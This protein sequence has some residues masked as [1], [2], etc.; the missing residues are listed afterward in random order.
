VCYYRHPKDVVADMVED[1]SMTDQL[2]GRFEQDSVTDQYGDNH[3]IFASVSSALW[4][5]HWNLK[6][7]SG[8]RVMVAVRVSGD[9]FIVTGKR[10]CH[11]VYVSAGNR[12][13]Q[14]R[15]ESQSFYLLGVIPPYDRDK[16]VWAQPSTLNRVAAARRAREVHGLSMY[17][18][19]EGLGDEAQLLRVAGTPHERQWVETQVLMVSTDMKEQWETACTY[20]YGC[21]S[22]MAPRK[23]PHTGELHVP[24]TGRNMADMRRQVLRAQKTGEYG[25][26]NEWQKYLQGASHPFVL[27]DMGSARLEVREYVGMHECNVCNAL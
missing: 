8:N 27:P 2:C 10:G 17:H 6:L 1:D 13:A 3:R 22:C 18:M 14:S 20:G 9:E 15:E 25:V 5:Q 7:K 11:C 21:V 4:M 12:K 24:C 26:A 19:L 16:S 23:S